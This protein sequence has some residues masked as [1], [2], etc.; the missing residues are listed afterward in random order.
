MEAESFDQT[1][2]SVFPDGV[3]TYGIDGKCRSANA[4][5]SRLLAIPR[6]R[7]LSQDFREIESWKKAGILGR[8]EDTLRTGRSYLWEGFLTSS[9]GKS[10]WLRFRLDR[11]QIGGETILLTTFSDVS[12]RKRIEEA[13]RLTRLSVDYAGDF[14][15]W[16]APDGRILDVNKSSCARYGYSRN[17]MLK[18]SIFDLDT[19]L[20]PEVWRAR[21]DELKHAKSSTIQSEHVTRDGHRFPVEVTT[22]YVRHAGGEYHVAFVRDI[23]E[24]RQTE[25]TL[26]TSQAQL[27]AAM[28][29]ADLVNWEFDVETGTFTFNDRFYALYGTTAEREGGYK[30]P[31]DVYAER[32]VHPD[33]RH[34][35][36]EE[37]G[38]ALETP[39]P[40]YR[41][42]V[43]HRMIR[44]DGEIRHLAI[45]YGITKDEHG[46]TIKTHGS[47]QDI[48]ERMRAAEN[49]HRAREAAEAANRELEYAIHRANQAAAEAQAANEAKSLFLANMSHEIRTPMNGII[50]MTELLLDTSLTREQ[51]DFADTIRSS[52]DTL[53]GVIGD[54]LDFSKIEAHK[55]D[56]ENIDFDLRTTLEDLTALLAFRAYEK[57]IELTTL[58]EPDVP[59]RLRGDPG[60][61]RQVLTNLAGNG[62]KFTEAGEVS[63]HVSLESET[64][65]GS[66]I[67][68]TVQDTGIGISP[69]SLDRLFQPFTQ[70]DAST[71]RRYGGTGLG[72]SIAKGLVDMMGGT[73]G[74][75]SDP[76]A[77]STFWFTATFSRG[78]AIAAEREPG[79]A[80]IAG[81]RVLAVD[82]NQ[83]NRRVLAGMLQAWGCRHTEVPGADAA[84]IALREAVAQGDPFQ[85]AVLDMHMPGVDGEMLGRAIKADPIIHE[86]ALIMMTSGAHRGDALRMERAGFSAYLVKPVRQSQFYDCLAVVAA[87]RL[88]ADGSQ[89]G[90]SASAPAPLITRHTLS[91]RVKHRMHVLLAEDNSVNQK[92]A[93]KV[94]ERLGYNAEVVDTGLAALEALRSKRYDVVLMDVQM[95]EMDGLE[96][97]RRI[98]EIGSDVVDPFIPIIALTAHATAGDRQD[99]L[100]AGMDDYLAKPIKPAELAETLERWLHRARPAA[101]AAA[102]HPRARKA[103]QTPASL[104]PPRDPVFDRSV[105]IEILDGDQEAA[106]EILADFLDDAPRLV[107]GLAEAVET[108]DLATAKLKAHTLKG[109]SAN[110][111][112]LELRAAAARMEAAAAAGALAEAASLTGDMARALSTLQRTVLTQRAAS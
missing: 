37:V 74:A 67:R 17:E 50:G 72:L 20:A 107:A 90:T 43:E 18:L 77:G 68:F 34:L 91:E 54:I 97:T 26:K 16:T 24:R 27:A 4:A 58:V 110:V 10:G 57:G 2:M 60:R 85:V 83:T 6:E 80:D 71:T 33:D 35:V 32:F 40:N 92:V 22:N 45:R 75:T 36:A 55:L 30:M 66:I 42:H 29:L 14:V 25:E 109:A 15:H 101:K 23:S 108:A 3:I 49:E 103:A 19:G 31:A 59:S 38:K 73:I 84:L 56:I 53:L 89:T 11:V 69:D 87:R 46:R 44:P 7:L 93:L 13:L 28:D 100:N 70:A 81:L 105:L 65:T 112:A 62:I 12:R 111:G 21:W 96:A 8:A 52:A 88:G 76:G 99:C 1:L 64:E 9:G 94:L 39:D 104:T 78:V 61:L 63:I 48:T 82:D 102:R 106:G 79:L 86:T 95:P 5:A 98:R 51:R 41:A 47:N